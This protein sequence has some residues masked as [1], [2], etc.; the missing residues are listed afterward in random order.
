MEAG[1]GQPQSVFGSVQKARTGTAA[2]EVR[3]EKN[4]R[5][6]MLDLYMVHI[7]SSVISKVSIKC[8]IMEL[9]IKQH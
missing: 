1:G 3:P 2:L 5:K 4:K 7:G 8:I 6:R 9:V